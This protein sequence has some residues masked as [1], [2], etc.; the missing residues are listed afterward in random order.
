MPRRRRGPEEEIQ[1]SCVQW[2]LVQEN[3]GK[4]TFFHP[5]NGGFRSKAEAGVFKAMGV[6]AGVPDLVILYPGGRAGFV[7]I[8][9]GKG[10][11]TESQMAWRDLLQDM[12]FG[13]REVRSLDDLMMAVDEEVGRN[14]HRRAS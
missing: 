11:L 9:A 6:R 3:L 8:K 1:R 7:E 13:W 2:L 5:A 12:G 14:E 4:L 10:R